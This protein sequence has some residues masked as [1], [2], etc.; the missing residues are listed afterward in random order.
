MRKALSKQKIGKANGPDEISAEILKSSHA[1]ISPLLVSLFNMLFNNAE[2]L[3][4]CSLGYV[5]PIFKGGDPD[6]PKNYRGITLNKLY[7][8]KGIFPSSTKLTNYNKLDQ[9]Y[10]KITDFQFGYQKGIFKAQLTVFS[11]DTI[12]RRILWQKLLSE[13]V[14]SKMINAIKAMYATIRS[15]IKH[16]H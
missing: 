13:H 5:I 4:N 6:N 16:N 8:C 3:E 15:I 7:Y 9:K 11:F 12:N 14:S 1:V 2:Y 10:V